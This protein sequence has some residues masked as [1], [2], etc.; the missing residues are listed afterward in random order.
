MSNKEE[1]NLDTKNKILEVARQKFAQGGYKGVSLNSLA[2]E[3]GISKPALYYYFKSK[4]DLYAEIVM[5]AINDLRD[6]IIESINLNLPVVE[7]FRLVLTNYIRFISANRNIIMLL[8]QKINFK[9]KKILKILGQELCK[10]EKALEPLIDRVL[11]ERRTKNKIDSKIALKMLFGAVHALVTE[12]F[13]RQE[14]D[15]KEEQ[16]KI[17]A[18]KITNYF[19][20]MIFNHN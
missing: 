15:K 5:S 8:K 6:Q 7:S 3:V 17:D 13:I 10:T 14:F 16:E 20:N 18:E 4:E 11:S 12:E 19:I 2:E 1:K 9:D